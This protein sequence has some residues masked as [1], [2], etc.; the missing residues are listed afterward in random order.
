MNCD[1]FRH[2]LE[3]L[4]DG[5]LDPAPRAALEAHL[6]TCEDCRALT[7]DLQQI[8]QVSGTLERRQPPRDAWTRIAAQLAR[9]PGMQ[10]A[11]ARA[12]TSAWSLSRWLGLGWIGSSSPW[13]ALGAVAGLVLI[14]GGGL[15]FLKSWTAAPPASGAASIAGNVE[16]RRLVQSVESE[17]Q[18]AADHYKKAIDSLQAVANEPDSPLDSQTAATLHTNM[19]VID[20][21]IDESQAALRSQPESQVAQQSLF[22]AFR[23]KVSLLQDTIALMNEL[24]KGNQAGAARVAEGLN[25]S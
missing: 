13:P 22:E 25:K 2:S 24:R 17:L 18:Q 4:I 14:V 15:F 3:A 19:A 5:D 20:K 9:E 1:T 21:A 23:R 12:A 6:A 16:S 11:D 7:V 10:P 8:R